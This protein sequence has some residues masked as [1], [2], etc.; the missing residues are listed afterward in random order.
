MWIK[1]A[2]L[3]KLAPE[4]ANE[5]STSQNNIGSTKFI[6]EDATRYYTG[7]FEFFS[8][9]VTLDIHAKKLK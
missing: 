4:I 1:Q 3:G 2:D 6:F 5:I 8:F 9:F 7:P